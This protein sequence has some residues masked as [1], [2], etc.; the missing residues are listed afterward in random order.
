MGESVKKSS[1]FGSLAWLVVIGFIGLLIWAIEIP[2]FLK[3]P[4]NV[5]P[6]IANLRD[7]DSA[8][9][10]WALENGK[11]NGIVTWADIKPYLGR[12]PEGSLPK[13]PQGGTY[14]IGKIGELPTCSLGKTNSMH[15]L[16]R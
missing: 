15:A 13:C 8:K 2:N 6:C 11:T 14:T 4:P 16:P 10:Q 9:Q 3:Q 7:F 12:G 5:R 1:Q